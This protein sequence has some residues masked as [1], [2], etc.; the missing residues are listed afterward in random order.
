MMRP[1]LL[2]LIAPAAPVHKYFLGITCLVL[3]SGCGQKPQ[4]YQ[5]PP[6]P[7][8]SEPVTP[9]ALQDAWSLAG[10]VRARTETGY[11]F[12]TGGRVLERLVEV[13]DT[14]RTGEVLA[15]IDPADLTPLVHARRA[16][17]VAANSELRLAKADLAR[18]ERLHAQNFVSS[19]NVDRARAAVAVAQARLKSAS[20]Q[21]R[22]ADNA[23][24]YRNLVSKINGVV[25]ALQMEPGQVVAAGTPVIRVAKQGDVEVAVAIPEA[26]LARSRAITAWEVHFPGLPG[27]TW[28]AL[29]RELSPSADPAS[30]TYAAR[31]ALQGDTHEIALGMSAVAQAGDGQSRVL[32]VPLSALFSQDSAPH[33]WVIDPATHTVTARSVSLGAADARRIQVTRGLAAGDQVVIA[34]ANLLR[35]GQ[36]IRLTAPPTPP[37]QDGAGIAAMKDQ[38]GQ[39]STGE[40]D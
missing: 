22:Q 3:A 11:A 7:V 16:E 2:W 1:S 33:V 6:R 10:D 12:Q 17:Q 21:L 36:K 18:A 38:P 14:V 4:P 5:E 39:H 25:T 32:T 9:H 31:L 8:L 26:E 28:T 19:A 35:Q 37:V 30:R 34:G 29:L 23:F 40:G 13:G 20:A 27:R 15:R 24:S